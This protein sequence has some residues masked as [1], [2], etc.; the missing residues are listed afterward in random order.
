[1]NLIMKSLPS[2][3]AGLGLLLALTFAPVACVNQRADP[4]LA[5]AE[6]AMGVDPFGRPLHPGTKEQAIAGL[7]AVAR[8]HPDNPQIAAAVAIREAMLV[9]HGGT[10]ANAR[11]AWDKVTARQAGLLPRD[12]LL[13]QT[14]D[15]IIWYYA[16]PDGGGPPRDTR[17]NFFGD[18]QANA[19][20]HAG[21]FGQTAASAKDLPDLYAWLTLNRASITIKVLKTQMTPSE[22]TA[23]AV[24]DDLTEALRRFPPNGDAELRHKLRAAI[25][26]YHDLATKVGKWNAAAFPP[27]A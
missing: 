14:K 26:D 22:A 7:D 21:L 12:R 16:V 27:P 17:A 20:R 8:A 3:I 2:R 6:S 1:M 4:A 9:T 11:G 15:S 10:A 13:L 5:Q 23:K 18:E 24:Y 25:Q 19:L